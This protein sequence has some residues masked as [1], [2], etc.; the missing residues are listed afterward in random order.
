[1]F[2]TGHH[3]GDIGESILMRLSR[4]SG[5]QGLCSPREIS[6]ASG[7]IQ[8]VRP[9][10]RWTREEIRNSL[11][12]SGI[13]WQEDATN[14]GD[15]NYRARIRKLVIPAWENA[16]DRP[17]ATGIARSHALLSEDHEALESIAESA[18]E[19]LFQDNNSLARARFD[20]NPVA[21]QR[22]LL[23]RLAGLRSCE[24]SANVADT[25]LEIID[26]GETAVVSL[27][28]TWEIA[29]E[30]ES[31]RLRD[32]SPQSWH[33]RTAVIPMNCVTY[34]PDGARI[35]ARIEQLDAAAIGRIFAGEVDNSQEVYLRLTEKPSGGIAVRRRKEG[36]AFK[37]HGKSSPQKLK[38]LLINRKIDRSRRDRLPIFVGADD[39]ILWVPG[40]PPQADTLIDHS[41]QAA[42]RLT[43]EG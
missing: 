13:S 18:W 16:S 20:R 15:A 19:T 11:R 10:L 14:S 37:P 7:C 26:A 5:L 4:G 29:C 12:D 36:D 25:I 8:F 23:H 34:L 42:L 41:Q 2:V 33:W 38:T 27:S 3:G 31:I 22:R 6:E 24:L 1:M 40:L 43:Y 39:R 32:R 30:N 21:I 17:L 9:L 28:D 35:T